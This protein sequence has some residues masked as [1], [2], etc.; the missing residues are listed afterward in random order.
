MFFPS[1]RWL[2]RLNM[3][4]VGYAERERM[5]QEQ[6]EDSFGDL[7]KGT[8]ADGYCRTVLLTTKHKHTP[9]AFPLDCQCGCNTLYLS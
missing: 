6:G 2:S 4:A 7:L 5:R 3:A 1:I 8:S 9:T